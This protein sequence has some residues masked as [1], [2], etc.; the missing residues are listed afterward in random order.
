MVWITG[1]ALTAVVGAGLQAERKVRSIKKEGK[2]ALSKVEGR[3][4]RKRKEGLCML[5]G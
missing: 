1:E 2:L 5:L 3:K 4:E